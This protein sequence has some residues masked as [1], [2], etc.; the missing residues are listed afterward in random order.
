[1]VLTRP[2]P[3]TK[4]RSKEL[5]GQGQES[6]LTV[7]YPVLLSICQGRPESSVYGTLDIGLQFE[8]RGSKTG[9][10]DALGESRCSNSEL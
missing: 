7:Q 2:Q 4:Q 5:R 1:M 3:L 8:S 9:Y 10:L 6:K